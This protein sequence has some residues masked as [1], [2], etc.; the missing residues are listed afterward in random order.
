MNKKPPEQKK[1]GVSLKL[2]PTVVEILRSQ[3]AYRSQAA[4]IEE[5]VK[6]MAAT[7]TNDNGRQSGG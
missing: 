4:Y 6:R 5:A 3:T 2:T 7:M 1:V